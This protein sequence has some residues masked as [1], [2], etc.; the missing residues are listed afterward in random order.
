MQRIFPAIFIGV[1]MAIGYSLTRSYI[2]TIL[3]GLALLWGYRK[4]TNRWREHSSEELRAQLTGNDWRLWQAAIGELK[5]RNEDIAPCA[6]RFVQGLLANYTH[7]RVACESIL[8]KHYPALKTELNGY[9]PMHD[10]AVSREKLSG[11]LGRFEEGSAVSKSPNPDT[12]E[13]R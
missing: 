2:L 8:K 11:L 12:T 5:R 3:F 13:I 4:D 10:V 7:E 1:M 6:A 9:S